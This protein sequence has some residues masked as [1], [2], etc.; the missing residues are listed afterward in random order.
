MAKNSKNKKQLKG[1]VVS[2]KMEKTV[3]VSVDT[4][5]RHPIYKKVVNK[6]KVFFAHTDMELEIGD[7]V[8]IEES[9]PYSK[10]IRWTVKEKNGTDRK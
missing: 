7:E 8:I 2:N 3:R 5:A 10:K 9:R 6:R 4:P 1:V